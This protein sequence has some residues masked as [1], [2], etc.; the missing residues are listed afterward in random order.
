[1]RKF[2]IIKLDEANDMFDYINN[3]NPIA[4]QLT[5]L[6]VPMKK[7]DEVMTLLNSLPSLVKHLIAALEVHPMKHATLILIIRRLVHNLVNKNE[8]IPTQE[9]ADMLSH[10]P[11]I[12]DNNPM[13]YIEVNQTTLFVVVKANATWMQTLQGQRMILQLLWDMKHYI[14]HVKIH[15]RSIGMHVVLHV[16]NLFS[17]F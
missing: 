12:F 1:M 13:C 17:F 8:K 2:L 7:D 6:E 16:L 4:D 5:C 10:Q 9:D 15:T 14:V 3:E 11:G